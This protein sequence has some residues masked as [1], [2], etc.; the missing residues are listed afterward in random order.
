YV[1]AV[2]EGRLVTPEDLAD[3]RSLRLFL[4]INDGELVAHRPAELTE[5][6]N[7]QIMR[8]LDDRVVTAAEELL[9]VDLQSALGI[10]YDRYLELTRYGFG[11]VY[12]TLRV[13][14]AGNGGTGVVAR[15]QLKAIE[16]VYLLA[17]A[18]RRGTVPNLS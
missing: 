13:Q 5:L 9:Q 4:R 1:R 10:G 6:L 8:I 16:P 3:I 11:Q 18:I 14:A 17:T 7:D 12:A 2:I 15:Q